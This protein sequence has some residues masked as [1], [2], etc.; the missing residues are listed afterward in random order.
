[1]LMK[2]PV[3]IRVL[4]GSL[5]RRASYFCHISTTPSPP[6]S[7]LLIRKGHVRFG[8]AGGSTNTACF[9]QNLSSSMFLPTLSLTHSLTPSLPQSLPHPIPLP[10]YGPRMYL[11]AAGTC[12]CWPWEAIGFDAGEYTPSSGCASQ[13]CAPSA[14]EVSD[15]THRPEMM[16]GESCLVL[17]RYR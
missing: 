13:R 4:R 6:L 11:A 16:A 7:S 9:F 5:S 2:N 8:V 14:Q 1:M 17:V 3:Q 10:A 12:D 15:R